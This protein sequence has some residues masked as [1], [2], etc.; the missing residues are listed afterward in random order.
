VVR[1]FVGV[2]ALCAA[3]ILAH[4]AASAQTWQGMDLLTGVGYHSVGTGPYVLMGAQLTQ[5]TSEFGLS[6]RL[7]NEFGTR[8]GD[9][10]V[11]LQA[12]GD[13]TRSRLPFYTFN[14]KVNAFVSQRQNETARNVSIEGTGSI[15]NVGGNL[16]IGYVGRPF[17]SFPW[18]RE[19]LDDVES[20]QAYY[21]LNGRVSAAILSSLGLRWSQNVA[22][23]RFVDEDT[24]AMSFV[25][26]P[27]VRVGNGRVS[28]QS[29]I[30]IGPEG[31]VPVTRL[32]YRIESIGS[33]DAVGTL[34][35]SVDTTSLR[36]GGPVLSGS[37]TLD[38]DW[39][40][41][42]ALVRVYQD[43]PQHPRLYF[44]IRPKF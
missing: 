15:G 3:V 28:L 26:G 39:W 12:T 44:S 30:V 31:M 13:W 1:Q 20:G 10:T 14:L 22:W 5:R 37:Y 25:T 32:S 43:D 17:A 6:L 41:V 9:S 19:D 24:S 36:G 8:Q 35:L 21:Y 33:G 29:G 27:D 2:L 11:S 38:A 7:A 42:Q 34:Q 4:Q 40:S 23:Q 18:D 16:E